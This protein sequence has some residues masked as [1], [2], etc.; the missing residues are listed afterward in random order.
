MLLKIA[1]PPVDD[2]GSNSSLLRTEGHKPAIDGIGY[3]RW[4]R[5]KENGTRFYLINLHGFVVSDRSFREHPGPFPATR[6]GANEPDMS[7]KRRCCLLTASLREGS[8]DIHTKCWDEESIFAGLLSSLPTNK[9]G[10]TGP[11]TFVEP[12]CLSGDQ[13]VLHIHDIQRQKS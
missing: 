11:A 8:I 5:D 10:K 13:S 3:I 4:S 2:G 12:A 6:F 9:I 1:N 7:V